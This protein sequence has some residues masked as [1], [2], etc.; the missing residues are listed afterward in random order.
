MNELLVSVAGYLVGLVITAIVVVPV[1]V[2]SFF[3]TTLFYFLSMGVTFAISNAYVDKANPLRPN[4][5]IMAFLM[6]CIGALLA[7]GSL[8]GAGITGIV[9]VLVTHKLAT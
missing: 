3:F 4:L 9:A 1:G 5:T 7:S 6:A 8:V 2:T